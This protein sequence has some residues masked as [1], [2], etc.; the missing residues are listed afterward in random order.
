MTDK[1]SRLEKTTLASLGA[2]NAF[3]ILLF[4]M[5]ATLSDATDGGWLWVRGLFA[6]VQFV[7]FD[8]T[9]VTTVQAMRDGRRSK[10]GGAT[11]VMASLA[12]VLIAIDVSTYPLPPAHAAY[13]IVL[14]LFMMHLSQPKRDDTI[15][16]ALREQ[17]VGKREQSVTQRTADLDRLLTDHATAVTQFNAECDRAVTAHTAQMAEQHAAVDSAWQALASREQELTRQAADLASREHTLARREAEPIHRTEIVTT[18]HVEVASAR[19]SW[20]ELHQL[21][22]MARQRDGL[23][24]S[25]LRRLVAKEV[26]EG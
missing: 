1:L 4:A 15:A 7:A 8:L 5:G 19:L 12:A 17:E 3:N 2:G 10:W 22:D 18:E 23:S 13:A 9:I 16:L 14:P 6:V 25:S 11:V 24:M 20:A 21:V 26:E